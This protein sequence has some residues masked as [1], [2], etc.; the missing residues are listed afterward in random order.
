MTRFPQW[1]S[2]CNSLWVIMDMTSLGGSKLSAILSRLSTV[3]FISRQALQMEIVVA[4]VVHRVEVTE[5]VTAVRIYEQRV[6]QVARE[7][8][9]GRVAPVGQGY[10][11]AALPFAGDGPRTVQVE[12]VVVAVAAIPAD[13]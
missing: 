3:R 8:I 2:D 13:M 11:I 1:V 12:P 6:A 10:P 9:E 4:P 5:A 7:I